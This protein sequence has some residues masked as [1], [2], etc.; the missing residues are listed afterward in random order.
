VQQQHFTGEGEDQLHYFRSV[1]TTAVPV[2]FYSEVS[3]VNI[4]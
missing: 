4:R 1:H 3:F 2:P